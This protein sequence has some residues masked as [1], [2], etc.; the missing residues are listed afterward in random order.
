M[1]YTAAEADGL[2]SSGQV[3][4]NRGLISNAIDQLNNLVGGAVSFSIYNDQTDDNVRNQTTDFERDIID[5]LSDVVKDGLTNSLNIKDR[6][7]HFNA[8]KGVILNYVEGLLQDVK[9]GVDQI[10]ATPSAANPT[11]SVPAATADALSTILGTNT[12][13]ASAHAGDSLLGENVSS[14]YAG[15]SS[16]EHLLGPAGHPSSH[17]G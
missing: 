2:N 15:M 11:A 4:P 17:T 3:V 8:I 7:E 12:G 14:D 1:V 13:G 16:V 5:P 6:I 9:S 10:T